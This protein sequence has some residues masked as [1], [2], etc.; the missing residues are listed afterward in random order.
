LIIIYRTHFSIAC[1]I[2]IFLTC[3]R[4]RTH[5]CRSFTSKSGNSFISV[6]D[7]IGKEKS[8][9]SGSRAVKPRAL[10]LGWAPYTLLS[11]LVRQAH[12]DV[13]RQLVVTSLTEHHQGLRDPRRAPRRKVVLCFGHSPKHFLQLRSSLTIET[14]IRGVG[15]HRKQTCVHCRYPFG[16][17]DNRHVRCC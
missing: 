13:P 8:P 5:S 2:F 4:T 16:R 11:V 9:R 6:T 7:F 15:A 14:G 10:S 3:N 17:D 12:L 1:S